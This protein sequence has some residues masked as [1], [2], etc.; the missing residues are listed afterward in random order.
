MDLWHLTI[1]KS[2]VDTRGFSSAAKAI[3][4]TQPTVSTHI[5]D[6]EEHYNCRLLDRIGRA[7]VPTRAGEVLYNYSKRLLSL[8]E[9]TESGMAQ[10]LGNISGRMSIGGSTIPA[11]YILP[12]VIGGFL[13]EYRDVRI[14]LHSGDTEQIINDILDYRLELGIVGA[15]TDHRRISQTTLINDE[16]RLIVAGDHALATKSELEPEELFKTPF[17]LRES[18][19]G[20]RK[21]LQKSLA[22]IGRSPRALSVVA[23][24]GS[25]AAVIQGI[26]NHVGVSIL[27]PIAVAGELQTGELKALTVRGLDLSRR[28]YLTLH[29]NRSPSP[30]CETFTKF[31]RNWFGPA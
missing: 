20:T 26:K 15:E 13:A 8:Y 9:E 5:K 16:M 6:L 25:T 1:F 22:A 31:T 7:T 12:E 3:N 21:S 28:F 10:F 2:V 29:K 11:G 17:I 24:F 18:G 14:A 4:L 19:S 27:S 23:E 30:L